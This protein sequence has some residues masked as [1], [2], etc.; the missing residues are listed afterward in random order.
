[1]IIEYHLTPEDVIEFTRF[2]VNRMRE[3]A[4]PNKERPWLT[5]MI[6]IAFASLLAMEAIDNP[7]GKIII[8]VLVGTLAVLGIGWAMNRR[9]L[10]ISEGRL[11]RL[12]MSKDGQRALGQR[13]LTISPHSLNI[14]AEAGNESLTWDRI[15]DIGVNDEYAFFY[16]DGE[17]VLIVPAR[18]FSNDWQYEDFLTKVKAYRTNIKQSPAY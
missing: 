18:A 4:G 6:G 14:E 3:R 15:N 12:F 5:M 10:P 1:M 11:R 7:G 8:I 13:R 9:A 17:A 16:L 2:H